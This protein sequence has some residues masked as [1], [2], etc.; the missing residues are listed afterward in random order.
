MRCLLPLLVLLVALLVFFHPQGAM[1][2]A[3][4]EAAPGWTTT[5]RKLEGSE[6]RLWY[7]ALVTHESSR[8]VTLIVAPV[9]TIGKL[10]GEGERVER[11][12]TGDLQQITSGA[13][14][15]RKDAEGWKRPS[16]RDRPSASAHVI[17]SVGF[18]DFLT[19]YD[20]FINRNGDRGFT[21]EVFYP[22]WR[23]EPA[24]VF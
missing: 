21:R 22:R 23:E 2:K 8:H 10:A 20:D 3:G 17:G 6:R 13:E 14:K 24:G 19:I 12:R 9:S 18:A 16:L 15:L 1:A 5:V 4:E 7:L 11:S